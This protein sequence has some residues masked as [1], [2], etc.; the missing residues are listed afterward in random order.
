VPSVARSRASSLVSARL[1]FA[2]RALAHAPVSLIRVR[3]QDQHCRNGAEHAI[4][5]RW[6]KH[7]QGARNV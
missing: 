7:I 1:R 5:P 4:D 6:R 2:L 3:N